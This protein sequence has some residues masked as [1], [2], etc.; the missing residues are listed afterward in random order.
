MSR[1]NEKH[2]IIK[3]VEAGSIAE[4]IELSSGDE[5]IRIN[6]KHIVYVFD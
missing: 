5:Q 3:D 4:Q 1:K 6:G 2:H